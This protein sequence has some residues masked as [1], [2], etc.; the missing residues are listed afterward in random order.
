MNILQIKEKSIL[1]AKK[2]SNKLT[3]AQVRKEYKQFRKDVPGAD[4]VWHDKDRHFY[5]WCSMYL[6]YK[7]IKDPNEIDE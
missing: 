5:K 3:E 7:H 1:K 6:D 4:E 2:L